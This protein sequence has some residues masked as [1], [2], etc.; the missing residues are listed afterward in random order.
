MLTK[1]V[2]HLSRTADHPNGSGEHGYGIVVPLNDDHRLDVDAWEKH[3]ADCTVHRFW[4]GQED[5]HGVLIETED[6]EWAFSYDPKSDYDD[7]RVFRMEAQKFVEGEYISVT[8]H[9]GQERPF[10]VDS[11]R[12][13]LD[14]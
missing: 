7:E 10:R 5:E 2:L 6:E 11:V 4:K 1:V 14:R 12:P 8:C 9:D 3:Q 13:Y